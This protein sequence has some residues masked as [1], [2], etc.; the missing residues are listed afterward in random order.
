[1]I[2]STSLFRGLAILF[3]GWLGATG[4]IQAQAI[5]SAPLRTSGLSIVDANGN[6]VRL[7]GV[8]LGGWMVME[9]WMTPAD[10]SG[11][12]DEYS[13]LQ[14]LDSRFG[15]ATEQSLIQTYRQ[16]WMTAQDLDNIQAQGLNLVRVPV[17]W[18]DF[19]ALNALG[20]T[21]PTLRSDA[22]TVLDSLIQA[23]SARGIYTIIDMHGVFG[24][25]STSDDTGQQNQ[26]AY[27]TSSLDQAST[28]QLWSAIAAHYKG[29]AGVAGYDLLNEPSGAPNT[30][31]VWTALNGLYQAVRTADPGHIVIMEGTFGNWDWS[32][33]P[34]P[35]TYS[36]TNVVYQM[37]EY[38]WSNETASGVETG[39]ANQ[40]TDFNNHKSWNVPAY[41]GEFNAFG[42]G[43]A[44]WS[45]VVGDFNGDGMNWSM[46]S[47][48]ATHGSGT[49]SWG[50]YNPTGTWPAVPNIASDSAATIA[51]DWARWTTASAF[52]INPM[53][54]PVITVASSTSTD[55]PALPAWGVGLL[56]ALLGLAAMRGRGFAGALSR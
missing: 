11:L 41:I 27:W 7:R 14:K 55:T 28:T 36:W 42:T 52:A 35:A 21:N 3:S 20:T 9:P 43:T 29:N 51:A 16:S 5:S 33:L 45:V 12:P 1:M 25:Q 49:D 17:W 53:I 26:N 48:K 47:Y 39:A 50:L 8:N 54:S 34:S 10:S 22:F 31:A 56:A 13:I 40:V 32:M 4:T 2:L 19:Y 15:V 23:A 18:G 46:W 37:H 38:Q 30:S 24:G 6:P 44:A